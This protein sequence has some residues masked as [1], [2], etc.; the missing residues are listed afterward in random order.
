MN[1]SLYRLIH[2][3]N[4]CGLNWMVLRLRL[5]LQKYGSIKMLSVE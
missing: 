5:S 4:G 2:L 1:V 3:K